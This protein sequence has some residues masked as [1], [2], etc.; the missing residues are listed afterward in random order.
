MNTNEKRPP[1]TGAIEIAQRPHNNTKP[2]PPYGGQL[3][4]PADGLVWLF[5]GTLAWEWA[6]ARPKLLLPPGH[7]PQLYRWPVYNLDVVI[8][9]TGSP[10][11]YLL[12][13]AHTLLA[14][15]ARYVGCIPLSGPYVSFTRAPVEQTP[16]RFRQEV[17]HAE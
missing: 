14:A 8:V 2:L 17:C 4:R 12:H 7:D 3:Q 9:D 15:G 10:D 5:V 13:V 16:A 6:D 11:A 1:L